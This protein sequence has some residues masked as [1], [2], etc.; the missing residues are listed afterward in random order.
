MSRVEERSRTNLLERLPAVE[1]DDMA[2]RRLRQSVLAQVAADVRMRRRTRGHRTWA[3]DLR[4][5]V[6][7]SVLGAVLWSPMSRQGIESFAV[8]V[9]GT[10]GGAV[11]W[12]R[13]LDA[14]TERVD[15]LDGAFRVEVRR[16][17]TNRHVLIAVPDGRIE[18]LGT[19][20]DVRVQAG[21]TRQV[22][23]EEG[24]VAVWVN[25]AGVLLGAGDTWEPPAVSPVEHEP[26]SEAPSRPASHPHELRTRA[27]T[28]R[29]PDGAAPED[30]AYLEILH[31]LRAS[32]PAEAR[33]GARVYLRRFPNGFRREEVARLAR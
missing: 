13:Q 9:R 20:F 8:S 17:A 23:V 29:P 30:V 3:L 7:V 32:R 26:A 16:T 27:A 19:T 22:H 4:A 18:D 15:L 21:R 24:R 28:T 33:E 11:R 25:R 12:S 1:L 10:D 5:V 6:A 14:S 2:A 31:L